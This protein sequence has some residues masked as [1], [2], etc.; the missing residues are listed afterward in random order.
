MVW[1]AISLSDPSRITLQG[2]KKLWR[3]R[4]QDCVLF[5]PFWVKLLHVPHRGVP[6]TALS[7]CVWSC[8]GDSA[9]DGTAT[10]RGSFVLGELSAAF[11]LYVS[12]WQIVFPLC[13]CVCVP[14]PYF[15]SLAGT[16]ERKRRK[17]NLANCGPFAVLLG[18]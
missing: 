16:A 18:T 5:P 9:D 14:P 1:L 4:W 2:N 3:L 7:A 8:G 15:R 17:K 13:A 11:P 10:F 6:A 12:T